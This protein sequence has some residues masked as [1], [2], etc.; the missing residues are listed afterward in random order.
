MGVVSIIEMVD[1]KQTLLYFL[2]ASKDNVYKRENLAS[3]AIKQFQCLWSPKTI[4]GRLFDSIHLLCNN[5][6]DVFYDM[7][8]IGRI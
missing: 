7:Q 8:G 3:I 4:L 6:F 5:D 1:L 2:A